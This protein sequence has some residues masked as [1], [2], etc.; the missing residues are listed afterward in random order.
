LYNAYIAAFVCVNTDV[1]PVLEV[2]QQQLALYVHSSQTMIILTLLSDN[3]LFVQICITLQQ[4]ETHQL[5]YINA[6]LI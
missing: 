4:I 1:N 3:V 6:I 2:N 5:L